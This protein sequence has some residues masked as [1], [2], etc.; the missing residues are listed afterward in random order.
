[1]KKEKQEVWYFIRGRRGGERKRG[2][3]PFRIGEKKKRRCRGGK[4]TIIFRWEWREKDIH[5]FGGIFLGGRIHK[6]R[7]LTRG[8]EGRNPSLVARER[9]DLQG[10]S[11]GRKR[12]NTKRSLHSPTSR[13]YDN[14]K[15]I[16]AELG[17]GGRDDFLH[18]FSRF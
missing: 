7:S 3:V 15:E 2:G 16:N 9:R 5:K 18:L 10:I 13:F 17:R 11:R 12:I 6:R 1:L 14:E 4:K 8:K